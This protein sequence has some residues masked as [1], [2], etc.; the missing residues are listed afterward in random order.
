MCLG[1]L[2]KKGQVECVGVKARQNRLVGVPL[3][4]KNRGRQSA[5][6]PEDL[7]SSQGYRESRRP[8]SG[9]RS[10]YKA[11]SDLMQSSSAMGRG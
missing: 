10:H 8:Q 1:T 6:H 3:G 11:C 7:R 4:L 5:V 2:L 9:E